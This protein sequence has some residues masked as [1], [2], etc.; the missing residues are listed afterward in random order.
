MTNS[1]ASTACVLQTVK[2]ISHCKAMLKEMLIAEQM[3]IAVYDGI[4]CQKNCQR[5]RICA[6]HLDR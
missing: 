3:G 1:K 4:K 5:R 6:V 2:H